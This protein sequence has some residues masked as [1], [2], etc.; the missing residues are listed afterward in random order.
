MNLVNLFINKIYIR[1]KIN[2]FQIFVINFILNEEKKIKLIKRENTDEV[3][4]QKPI[5]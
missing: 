2:E 4:F 5:L 3:N 1:Y